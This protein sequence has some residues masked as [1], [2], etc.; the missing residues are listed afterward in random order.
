M[1]WAAEWG[2]MELLQ[3]LLDAG[4]DVDKRDGVS[5]LAMLPSQRTCSSD[6]P[7]LCVMSGRADAHHVRRLPGSDRG[8]TVLHKERRRPRPQGVQGESI[9]YVELILTV[10]HAQSHPNLRALY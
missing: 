6:H 4:A 3:A 7:W 2:R 9:Y 8:R 1:H 5:K 10:P